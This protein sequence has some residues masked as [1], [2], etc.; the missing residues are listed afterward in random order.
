MAGGPRDEFLG[1][2]LAFD[3]WV[4]E[5]AEAVESWEGEGG[6]GKRAVGA[7]AALFPERQVQIPEL[8]T[9]KRNVLL[10]RTPSM[11]W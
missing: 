3:Y 1:S 4:S 6:G 5:E 8:V 2:T 11:M 10:H 7:A 9:L